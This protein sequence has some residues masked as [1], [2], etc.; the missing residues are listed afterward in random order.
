MKIN[1]SMGLLALSVSVFFIGETDA[2]G[3][4]KQASAPVQE[5]EGQCKMSCEK[6][7]GNSRSE[8]QMKKQDCVKSCKEKYKA[9]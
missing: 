2:F 1:K 9:K 7:T 8:L 4:K 6:V 3:K 5:T